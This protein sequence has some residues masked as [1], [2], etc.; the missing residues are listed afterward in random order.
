MT[1][2]QLSYAAQIV[3]SAG[4]V[5]SL[6]FV[7]LQIKQN[8][9]ALERGE[10]NATMSQW[11][12]IRMAIAQNREI[13]ELMTTGLEGEKKLDSADQLRLEQLLGE[14]AWASFHIWD[15]TRRGVFPSG[16]FEFSCGSLLGDV[17]RTPGGKAWW[18]KATS[19]GL[20]PDFVADVGRYAGVHIDGSGPTG[21][22]V[23]LGVESSH[24]LTRRKRTLKRR[25][26]TSRLAGRAR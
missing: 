9:A 21:A 4:V 14:Y 1:L 25:P 17:L 5:L 13:G 6:L 3:G 2:E 11:T 15:R 12:V 7:G 24:W 18:R 23:S 20:I 16:T 8:T 26:L 10:H 22:N 19:V